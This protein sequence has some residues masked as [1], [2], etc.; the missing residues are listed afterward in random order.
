MPKALRQLDNPEATPAAALAA[1]CKAAGD[2]LRLDVLR[3]LSRDSFGVQELAGI[4]AMPQPGM[5]HHLKV[6]TTAGLLTARREGNSIFYRRAL[7]KG[8]G[9]A[10]DLQA[11]L[12]VA[13]DALPLAPA[14]DARIGEVLAERSA[15][16]RAFFEKHADELAASQALLCELPQY[17]APLQELLEHA[18]LPR[19]PV[20]VEVG[21]G[22]GDLL[23]ELARRYGTAI[24]LDSSDEMLALARGN[25]T[26][27]AGVSLVKGSLEDYESEQSADLVVLNMV[28]HHLP[29]PLAALQKLA[30]VVRKGGYLLIADLGPHGQE[31][32]RRSLG[33][34]WLGFLPQDLGDWALAAGFKD[35]QSLYLGL[36]N[37]FQIQLRLFRSTL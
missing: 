6:L 11:S 28:L 8:A 14:Y 13:V 23:K 36:K 7:P 24:G 16:S 27:A 10:A 21:P 32:T 26:G 30:R 15:Q 1:L 33:D 29:S 17:L 37:G 19:R 9:A 22:H 34:V 35:A 31:W 2:P 3:V 12:Y 20:V 18:S 5:S 4:F 25:L